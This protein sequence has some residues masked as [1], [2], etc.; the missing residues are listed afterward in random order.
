MK[1]I[2][3]N[4]NIKLLI[5]LQTG[6]HRKPVHARESFLSLLIDKKEHIVGKLIWSTYCRQNSFSFWNL[7]TSL[8]TLTCLTKIKAIWSMD[9]SVKKKISWKT[10]ITW[11]V[12][13]KTI[14]W[15]NCRLE[16][17]NFPISFQNWIRKP[18]FNIVYEFCKHKLAVCFCYEVACAWNNQR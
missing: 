12:K 6:F 13:L 4:F 18:F 7:S 8:L 3:Q 9:Y 11:Y 14:I 15:C 17:T 2:T 5:E 1:V 16:S 10:T